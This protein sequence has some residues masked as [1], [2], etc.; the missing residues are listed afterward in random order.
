M[1]S[2]NPTAPAHASGVQ[3]QAAAHAADPQRAR[4][5]VL[6]VMR[7]IQAR[8]PELGAFACLADAAAL[9]A[10]A[11]RCAGPLAGVP[12]G[13][14]DIFDTLDLPTRYGS[15]ALYPALPA[16]HDAPVVAALRRTGALVVGKTTTTEFAYLH[17]T[18]TRNPA[19]PGRTPGGSSAGS[20]AAVAA[21]LLPLALG[22]QTGGSTIRPASYCGVVGYMPTALWL[23]KHGLKCFS[24]SLDTV[25]L[26]ARHVADAAWCAQ[27]LSG[28]SL[29]EDP[30]AGRTVVVGVIGH[31]PWG[32]PAPAAR[33]AVETAATA[34]RDGGLRIQPVDLPPI[35]G[36]AFD[37]H[38]DIQGYE[39]G[40]AL[41][42]EW[43]TAREQLSPILGEYLDG[44]ASITAAA[45]ERAQHVAATARQE[46]DA[47]LGACDLLLTPSAPDEAPAGYASTGPSTFNRLWTLLGWPCVSVPGLRGDHGAPIGVQLVGRAGSDARVLAVAQRLETALTMTTGSHRGAE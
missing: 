10:Q 12:V 43:T 13:V 25:G 6:E 28:R 44:A 15:P 47:W 1:T 2:P 37:A 4:T 41:R 23:P 29:V 33:R 45:Y 22:S 30:D 18:A 16:R 34:L 46:L 7:A 3:A 9:A 11:G 17:P 21:G 39:A 31:H 14:K 27:A 26:F 8:E 38:A 40:T 36:A 24:W 35:A 42:H 5:H 20:A 32:E 19:A